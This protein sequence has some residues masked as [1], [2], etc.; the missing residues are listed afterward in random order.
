MMKFTMTQPG[1]IGLDIGATRIKA[2][3]VVEVSSGRPILVATM[4]L[5]RIDPGG[6]LSAL[7]AQRLSDAL[8]RRGFRGRQVVAAAPKDASLTGL[9]KLPPS[10]EGDALRRMAAME[11]SRTHKTEPAGMEVACWSVPVAAHGGRPVTAPGASVAA[12]TMAVGCPHTAADELIDVLE[13]QGFTVAGLDL[14]AWAMARACQPIREHANDGIIAAIDLGHD[15]ASFILLYHGMVVYERTLSGCG[16]RTLLEAVH[17]EHELP[18][19]AVD[20][21]V[22]TLGFEVDER[23]EPGDAQVF[24]PVRAQL[25]AHA[26]SIMRELNLSMQYAAHQYPDESVAML[27]LVGG[28]ASVPGVAA[29]INEAIDAPVRALR[30]DDTVDCPAEF[31]DEADATG[32]S[33]AVGLSRYPREAMR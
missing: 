14:E 24:E 5:N 17:G 10:V 9:L 33:L 32:L 2:A 8:S 25:D 6:A 20:Y 31:E 7:D 26:A 4:V 21:A 19:P 22:F 29:R 13:T 18:G 27:L 28:G 11:L 1:P 16:T 30:L 23:G 12:A 15:G 3:Q